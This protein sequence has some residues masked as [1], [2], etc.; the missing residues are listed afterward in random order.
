MTLYLSNPTKQTVVFYFR[1]DFTHEKGGA[2]QFVEIASGKQQELGQS[3]SREQMGRVM[4]Q[5]HRFGARDAAESHGELEKFNGL[6]Y[7]HDFPVDGNEIQMAHDKVVDM[8]Q[9]RSATE[10]TR[11]A[12]GFDRAANEKG[13]GARLARTTTVE[14]EQLINP[15]DRPTGDEVKFSLTV[16]PEGHSDIKLPA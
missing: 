3:W 12:L 8:Q 7:R 9:A 1:T 13:R 5:L 11:A 2:P 15:R 14:V 4:E 10:A 6:L 16:D